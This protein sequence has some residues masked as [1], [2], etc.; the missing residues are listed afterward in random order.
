MKKQYI[1]PEA[2]EVN[3][4]MNNQILAGSVIQMDID[5]TDITSADDFNQLAPSLDPFEVD[6]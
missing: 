5:D 2:I 1:A 3:F 6:Y 4:I